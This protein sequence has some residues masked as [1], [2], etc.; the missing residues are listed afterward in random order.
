MIRQI[1][2]KSLSIRRR[3]KMTPCCGKKKGRHRLV[4]GKITT[5]CNKQL[6]RLNRSSE[7]FWRSKAKKPNRQMRNQ[8]SSLDWVSWRI[9]KRCL[10][11]ARSHKSWRCQTQSC[12][13]S[14]VLCQS[15]CY[16]SVWILSKS[17]QR[18]ARTNRPV[19]KLS[20]QQSGWIR[21]LVRASRKIVAQWSYRETQERPRYSRVLK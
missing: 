4:L 1:L 11:I 20:G 3:T 9:L 2:V 21:R 12:K 15:Q 6:S 13:M 14:F 19:S 7:M 8:I 18:K 5:R 16:R 17:C 10:M